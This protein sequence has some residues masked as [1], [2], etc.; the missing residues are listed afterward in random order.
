L[1]EQVNR[2]LEAFRVD[3]GFERLGDEF[4]A[5]EKAA[6]EEQGIPFYF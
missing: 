2:F 4:L 3:G 5:E 6:F 1:R